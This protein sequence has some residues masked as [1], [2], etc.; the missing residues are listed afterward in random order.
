MSLALEPCLLGLL[1]RLSVS[2]SLTAPLLP[3]SSGPITESASCTCMHPYSDSHL[4]NAAT[5]LLMQPS[6]AAY[7]S[8][9]EMRS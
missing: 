4:I 9:S 1:R 2:V 7:V 6:P 5:T 8:V 3:P